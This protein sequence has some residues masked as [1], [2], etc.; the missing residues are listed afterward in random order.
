M[1]I[2]EK[3][4]GALSCASL[5]LVYVFPVIGITLFVVLVLHVSLESHECIEITESCTCSLVLDC[6][7]SFLLLAC[8]LLCCSC[9]LLSFLSFSALSIFEYSAVRKDDALSVLVEF[10]YLEVEFFTKLS[11]ASVFLN[12]VLRSSK[13]FYTV[14]ELDNCALVENFDDLSV[15]DRI[16]SE[17]CL[18]VVPRIV[19][20]L[21]V[22]EAET[23]VFLVDFENLNIDVCTDLCELRWMLNLLSPREV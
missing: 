16:L 21:L 12:K 10:D 17:D 18:E 3:R 1:S 14:L 9:C 13:S 4:L 6:R 20:K 22:A 7:C 5:F 19:L 15:V 8:S 23:T 11:L 2:I